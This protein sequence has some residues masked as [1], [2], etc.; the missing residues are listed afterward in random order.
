[1]NCPYSG[2]I[3]YQSRAEAM[4]AASQVA[5]RDRVGD[6]MQSY[7]CRVCGMIHIGHRRKGQF[8]RQ[9]KLRRAYARYA[10]MERREQEAQYS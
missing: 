5:R 1:M 10:A 6:H 9:E 4:R 2:K 8:K 7:H 3:G